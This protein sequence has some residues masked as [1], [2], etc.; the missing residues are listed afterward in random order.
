MPQKPFVLLSGMPTAHYP[1]S[2]VWYHPAYQIN[3][4]G[5]NE[6]K[7]PSFD[8][9]ELYV[10]N[11]SSNGSMPTIE[12]AEYFKPD[13]SPI[14]MREVHGAYLTLRFKQSVELIPFMD[15]SGELVCVEDSVLGIEAFARTRGGLVYEIHQQFLMLW[16]EYALEE[17]QYLSEPAIELKR[18]LKSR[19]E[20]TQC[21]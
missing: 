1:R 5:S 3:E 8:D 13:L 12:I 17:D 11:I 10:S 21:A 14:I 15:E 6:P 4:G 16:R 9:T 19:L 20:V 2:T 18:N 7:V